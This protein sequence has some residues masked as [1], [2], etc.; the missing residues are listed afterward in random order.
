MKSSVRALSFFFLHAVMLTNQHEGHIRPRVRAA[1][2]VV[3]FFTVEKD[4]E[5]VFWQTAVFCFSPSPLAN[6]VRPTESHM[7]THA[8]ECAPRL[9]TLCCACWNE[10]CAMV[11]W[12]LFFVLLLLHKWCLF[13]KCYAWQFDLWL[14]F[15]TLDVWVTKQ[16]GCTYFV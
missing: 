11:V 14:V 10:Y 5:F 16:Y 1:L 13:V 6:E 9:P 12:L 7:L 15:F 2:K 4:L 8:I 3:R